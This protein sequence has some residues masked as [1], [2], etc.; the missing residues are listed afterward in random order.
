MI[1]LV[2]FDMD[3]L[4]FDTEEV[5]CRAFLEVT[6]EE[7]HPGSRE[8]FRE[9]IGL[10]APDIQK[11]YRQYFG[12]D[13]DAVR[14]YRL[15]GERKLKIIREEG[16]PVKPG[17]FDLLSEIDRLGLKKAVAS[18]SDQEMIRDNLA[19]A[20][21]SG[22]FDLIVSTRD[23]ARG[24][25]YPD[26]FLAVC[27]KL[28]VLPQ[29]ALVLEDSLNGVEAAVAGGIPVI[30]IPDILELPDRA[31]ERCLAVCSSL[32]QVIPLLSC[33]TMLR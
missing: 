25:P 28:H 33:V 22:R 32:D 17:L 4:M 18:S 13:V 27:Q 15:G 26:V 29:E 19:R 1:K 8:Q 14:L 20:G 11:K 31:K 24:K 3:G 2:I 6:R 16:L 7:G 10:N 9:I 21:L 23:F 30:Q 5:M 12:D